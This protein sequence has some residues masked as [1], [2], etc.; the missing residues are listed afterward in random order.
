MRPISMFAAALV[1]GSGL[2]AAAQQAAPPAAQ[3][4]EH[5][6]A[7]PA[8]APAGMAMCEK[9]PHHARVFFIAPKNGATVG[10]DVPV[11]FGVEGI[12]VA[13]SSDA[14]PGSGHHHLLI[15]AKELPPLDAPIP[16]DATHKHYGKGQTEDTIHLE[17][18]THTLQ[19]DFADAKHLQFDPPIVSKK[20]TI[21]VK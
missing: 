2:A 21:H 8:A 7:H 12:A 4:E 11:K 3:E 19:L 10:Q 13:P 1:L 15:D 6:A 20:I 5:A 18:G 16:N 17:P 14:K 9:A